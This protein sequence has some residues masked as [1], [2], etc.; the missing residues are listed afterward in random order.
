MYSKREVREDNIS[1]MMDHPSDTT[2]T[3]R[4]HVHE[5]SALFPSFRQAF[6]IHELL[7][8]IEAMFSSDS[9]GTMVHFLSGDE[10]EASTNVMDEACLHRLAI[11][12]S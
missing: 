10:G 6:A 2:A 4:N 12:K 9:E 1:A 7:S 5:F 11:A 8:L 3:G